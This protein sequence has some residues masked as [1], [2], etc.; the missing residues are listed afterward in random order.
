MV[1][2]L[3]AHRLLS[4]KSQ[5]QLALESG[6]SQTKISRYENGYLRLKTEDKERL[7]AAFGID[8]KELFP[9]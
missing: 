8:L 6:I 7:A 2:R 3:K 5:D 4:G 1:C 9:E